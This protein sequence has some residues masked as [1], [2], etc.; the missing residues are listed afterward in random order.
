MTPDL[1]TSL[2]GDAIKLQVQAF[3]TLGLD[4]SAGA[5][6]GMLDLIA[7]KGGLSQ[8]EADGF[9]SLGELPVNITSADVGRALRG[10][11]GDES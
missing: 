10:P 2:L 11:W 5:L 7:S 3:E 1:V 6:R 9:K 8:A 4:F